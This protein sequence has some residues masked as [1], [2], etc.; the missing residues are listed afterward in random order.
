MPQLSHNLKVF[1]FALIICAI[2]G[3]NSLCHYLGQEYFGGKEATGF[4]S[5]HFWPS[6]K[7]AFI[8]SVTI[9]IASYILY[10][11]YTGILKFPKMFLEVLDKNRRNSTTSTMKFKTTNIFSAIGVLIVFGSAV[12]GL[13]FSWVV[14]LGIM[15]YIPISMLISGDKIRVLDV[16]IWAGAVTIAF[17]VA[18]ILE[19][20]CGYILE[21]TTTT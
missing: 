20:L 5:R 15:F 21:E 13:I 4:F 3:L 19:K 7:A 16:L 1:K 11:I 14:F 18:Q 12:F 17:S 10:D 2:I 6:F 8:L 9:P